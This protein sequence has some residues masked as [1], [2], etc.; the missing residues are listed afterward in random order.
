MDLTLDMITRCPGGQINF[1]LDPI[2]LILGINL[3]M[4]KMYHNTKDEVSV[5]THSTVI[6]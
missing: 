2:T 1:D 6:A 4:V 5:S 3:A